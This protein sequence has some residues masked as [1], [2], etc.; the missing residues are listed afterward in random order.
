MADDDETPRDPDEETPPGPDEEAP[1]QGSMTMME[2]LVELRDR[3]IRSAL[4]FVVGLI[5][6]QVPLPP[7]DD[8]GNWV[9]VTW[10]TFDIL[11]LPIG[12]IGNVQSLG[13]GETLFAYFQIA[14]ILATS[15][16]MPVIVY[17][18]IMFVLPA[19]LPHEKKYMFLAVPGMTFS[20]ALGIA[21][22]YFFILP[23]ALGFLMGWGAERIPPHWRLEYYLETVSS[24]L[25]W[26]GV[27]FE[28]PLAI[29]FLCK[30]GILSVA[31]LT[32]FRKYA[33]ILAFVI[34]AV[35]TPTPDPLNQTL[36]SL[37]LYLLFEIGILLARL[38]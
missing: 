33:L 10:R 1:E 20:F 12:G 18:I 9:N 29:F 15:L 8:K 26:M 16:G 7:P 6:T 24:L 2:H 25:F 36:V 13:P 11:G 14:M 17:Q 19:L 32:K 3:L 22:G 4:A 30:L 28:M 35:I 31:R 38:A 37:P 23:P 27:S 21:F 34:G 5:V